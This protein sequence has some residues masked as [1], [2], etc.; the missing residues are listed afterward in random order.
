MSFDCAQLHRPNDAALVALRKI[1]GQGQVKDD[2]TD[3]FLLFI[4]DALHFQ[5]QTL[6]GELSGFTEIPGKNAG[7]CGD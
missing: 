4:L 6:G 1:L 2:V 7:T 3:H 5:G